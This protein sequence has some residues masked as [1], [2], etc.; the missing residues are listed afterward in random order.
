MLTQHTPFIFALFLNFW[1]WKIFSLNMSLGFLTLATSIILY[2]LLKQNSKRYLNISLPLFILLLFFQWQTTTRVSLTY[3]DND[4]QRVQQERLGEYPTISVQLGSKTIW[5]PIAHWFEGRKE[6]IVFFRIQK[7]FFEA[8]DPNLYFFANHPRERV[9]IQE[10]EKFPYIL[11][12]FFLIG[13]LSLTYKRVNSIWI[14]LIFPIVLISFIDHKNALG[15]FS[16]FPFFAVT[17]T[18]GINIVLAK[19]KQ[20]SK[21]YVSH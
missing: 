13:I 3:L 8:I 14:P 4:E 19:I 21:K 18:Q 17:I 6:A 20:M 12:P 5:I 7:N 16:L 2:L 11:F 1:I 10:F 9:N 15:P